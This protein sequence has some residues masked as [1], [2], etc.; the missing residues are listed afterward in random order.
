M[1]TVR[2]T[3]LWLDATGQTVSHPE[4]L[5]SRRLHGRT[6]N[7][8]EAINQ[9]VLDLVPETYAFMTKTSK[10]LNTKLPMKQTDSPVKMEH[11]KLRPGGCLTCV[12]DLDPT[13]ID[14]TP[15]AEFKNLFRNIIVNM[16]VPDMSMLKIYPISNF[17]AI[18]HN[19]LSQEVA[20]ISPCRNTLAL[21]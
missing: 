9:T 20:N 18:V 2:A 7:Q 1:G 8:N 21:L 10:Q 17:H 12:L 13:S 15:N 3:F 14:D 19:H 6:Q 16:N 4:S 5:L 11:L